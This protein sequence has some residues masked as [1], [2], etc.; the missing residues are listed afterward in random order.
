MIQNHYD[1][2]RL[3]DVNAPGS[4][5]LRHFFSRTEKRRPLTQANKTPSFRPSPGEV[6]AAKS[7]ATEAAVFEQAMDV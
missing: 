2:W 4:L 3:P 1:P 6:V 7:L 5:F